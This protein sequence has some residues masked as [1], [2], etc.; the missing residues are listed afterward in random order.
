VASYSDPESNIATRS[1][2]YTI[3][4]GDQ[5]ILFLDKV[6]VKSGVG[7]SV[8]VTAKVTDSNGAFV[9]NR[10]V[11]FT[12][13][14]TGDLQVVSA[15]TDATG[16]ATATYTPGTIDFSNRT[17]DIVATTTAVAGQQTPS[18]AEPPSRCMALRVTLSSEQGTNIT[19]GYFTP[20]MTAT[21]LDGNGNPIPN[22]VLT[23]SSANSNAFTPSASAT[24]DAQGKASTTVA[25]AV[26]AGSNETITVSSATPRRIRQPRLRCN[27]HPL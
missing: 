26:A 24:T 20:K 9:P 22:K 12:R 13:T 11:T 10:I 17:V 15:T 8:T 27:R 1:L 18:K 5:V 7:D 23:F 6:Q 21:L 2:T 3:T 4:S 25:V 14:G 16:T 19:L